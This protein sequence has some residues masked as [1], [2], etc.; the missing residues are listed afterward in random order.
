[1]GNLFFNTLDDTINLTQL[2][3]SKF[4]P[5]KVQIKVN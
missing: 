5:Q 2:S 1:M 4:K 3:E